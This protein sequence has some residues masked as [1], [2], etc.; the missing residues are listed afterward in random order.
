MKPHLYHFCF[1][2]KF[3]NFEKQNDAKHSALTSKLHVRKYTQNSVTNHVL[4]DG[5]CLYSGY[6]GYITFSLKMISLYRPLLIMSFF[7]LSFIY[8]K[9]FTKSSLQSLVYVT[10]R[11]T[12]ADFK[13]NDIRVKSWLMWALSV[14]YDKFEAE[15]LQFIIF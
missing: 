15:E 1:S 13:M 3:H 14:K 10:I 9:I 12:M 5:L 2:L 4:D 11:V 6:C 7:S 8:K